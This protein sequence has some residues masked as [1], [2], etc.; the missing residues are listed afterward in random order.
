MEDKETDAQ[1]QRQLEK[2][3]NA[4]KQQE[5]L[6]EFACNIL[7]ELNITSFNELMRVSD[8]NEAI[9]VIF[10]YK[11]YH[12]ERMLEEFK[13]QFEL[14]GNGV[15]TLATP[16]YMIHAGMNGSENVEVEIREGGAVETIHDCI[17][18]NAT[19]EFCVAA[20]HHTTEY[21]CHII[22]PEYDSLWLSH[23][24]DGSPYCRCAFMKKSS[25]FSGES[26]LG[27]T[28]A[29][30]PKVDLPKLDLLRMK[31]FVLGNLWTAFTE[32]FIAIHGS[33]KAVEVLGAGARQIGVGSGAYLKQNK[34]VPSSDAMGLGG[35]IDQ[36]ESGSERYGNIISASPM[37]FSKEITQ[38]PFKDWPFEMCKQFEGFFNGL[39]QEVNPNLE[40]KYQSMMTKGAKT[41]KWVI[42]KRQ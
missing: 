25:H 37:L 39:C 16:M 33:E 5:F 14:K 29:K 20:S 9:K 23:L 2:D 6:S 26:D 42:T 28:V 21:L 22:N 13:K 4:Q 36:F 30:L 8:H 32:S 24:T 34:M 41:C 1:K 40:F 3:K 35:L 19:P 27:K 17:F 18:R 31:A 7:T 38:C 10:H 11:E 12:I 15:D